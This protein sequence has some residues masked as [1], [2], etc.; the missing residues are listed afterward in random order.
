MEIVLYP[1][2]APSDCLR[3]WIGVFDVTNAPA[4]SWFVDDI[5]A[6]PVPLRDLSSVR[7]DEML[8][9]DPQNTPRAF[10]GVYEFSG[11][12]PETLYRITVRVG[13]ESTTIETNTIPDS[14]TAQLDRSFNVL[15]VSCFHQAEDRGGLASIIVE[16]LKSTSLPHLTLLSGDQVYLDLPTL[17]DFPDDIAWLADKFERDYTLNWRGPLAYTGVLGA[18]PSVSIPDDHEYWNNYPHLSPFIQNSFKAESRDRWR[19]AAQAVYEGFQLAYPS[20]LGDP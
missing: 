10:S 4:L 7:P 12:T 14:V 18:A 15:L 17:Q 1:R 13:E 19:R 3:I 16:Q 6:S 20:N 9:E 8:S 2:V 5:A 11:L